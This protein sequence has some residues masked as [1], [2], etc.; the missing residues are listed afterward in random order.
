MPALRL[1]HHFVIADEAGA[2]AVASRDAIGRA[3]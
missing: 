2:I 3:G 1:G